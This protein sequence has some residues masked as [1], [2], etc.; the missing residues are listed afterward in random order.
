MWGFVKGF[1][2]KNTWAGLE[3]FFQALLKAL[4]SE[5]CIPP[6]RTKARK[7]RRANGGNSIKGGSL[8]ESPA[9]HHKDG[10]HG[11]LRSAYDIPTVLAGDRLKHEKLFSWIVI[12][13]LIA[14]I[15]INIFLYYKLRGLE[16]IADSVDASDYI[17]KYTTKNGNPPETHADWIHLLQQQEIYHA[18]EVQHWN[19]LLQ[20]SIEMLRKVE[21]TL[22]EVQKLMHVKNSAASFSSAGPTIDE[23]I[24][25]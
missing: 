1:I 13:M 19:G 2:E 11:V 23:P 17:L 4:Q 18:K 14:L 8:T 16:E 12:A 20:S 7:T 3:E 15:V 21:G 5:Y 22:M 6:A 24:T 10:G 9:L 25:T